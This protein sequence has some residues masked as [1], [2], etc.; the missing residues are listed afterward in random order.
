MT[1]RVLEKL[2]PEKVGVDFLVPI[3]ETSEVGDTP[4][5][6]PRPYITRMEFHKV[7]FEVPNTA[8]LVP[9]RKWA[10]KVV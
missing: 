5:I 2:C 6:V 10:L 3:K 4:A 7:L 1:R 9:P 8:I